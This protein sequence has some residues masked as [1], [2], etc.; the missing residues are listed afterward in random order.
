MG[1][2]LSV[3]ALVGC[4]TVSAPDRDRQPP[5]VSALQVAP[6]SVHES[7]LPDEQV[8][9]SVAQVAVDLSA[10]VMD[11]DGT[12]ARVVFVFEP[13]SN[14]R[15]ALSGPLERENGTQYG[16][17]LGVAIPLEDEVYT[18]RVFAVDDDSLASNQVTG[19]LRFEAEGAS[20]A[21]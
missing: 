3:L 1:L 5:S 14:P 19:Q 17:R 12:I 13:G 16:G 20:P 18:L 6:D 4:D 10:Q 15:E 8:Q 11:P 7:D 21:D 2:A 9:D